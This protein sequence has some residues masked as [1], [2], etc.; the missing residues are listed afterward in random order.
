MIRH[1]AANRAIYIDTVEARSNSR[2][3]N[4][5]SAFTLDFGLHDSSQVL[6]IDEI[7]G[8]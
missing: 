3:I 8:Y 4:F 6:P 2:N 5:C 7:N 1:S